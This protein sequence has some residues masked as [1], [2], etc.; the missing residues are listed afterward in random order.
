RYIKYN[1]I[2]DFWVIFSEIFQNSDRRSTAKAAHGLQ[3]RFHTSMIE[4]TKLNVSSSYK[5]LCRRLN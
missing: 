3:V 5:K 1:V 2:N 4:F